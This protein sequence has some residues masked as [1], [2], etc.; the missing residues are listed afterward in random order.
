MI[1]GNLAALRAYEREQ[2]ALDAADMALDEARQ[3]FSN[4]LFDAYFGKNYAAI[5]EVDDSLTDT[6]T[7]DNLLK[8][9]RDNW[10]T[11]GMEFRTAYMKVVAETCDQ[12]AKGADDVDEF[13][14]EFGL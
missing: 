9:L 14:R 12:I 7:M 10:T 4:D 8:K 1:D 6:D 2:D 3:E 13:R 5:D 11:D